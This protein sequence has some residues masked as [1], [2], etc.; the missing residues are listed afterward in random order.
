[1]QDHRE[2]DAT[3]RSHGRAAHGPRE[4]HVAHRWRAHVARGHA[5]AREGRHVVIGEVG[6][7][8]AHELVGP[9]YRIGV[10]T[11]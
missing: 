9:G 3:L 5:D 2:C 11:P 8:R 4:V 10:V 7:W 6:S 1:M